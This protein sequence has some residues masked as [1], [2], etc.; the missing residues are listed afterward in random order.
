RIATLFRARRKLLYRIDCYRA[1]RS[2]WLSMDS[3]SPPDLIEVVHDDRHMIPGVSRLRRVGGHQHDES[4]AVGRQ[5]EVDA[6]AQACEM[7]GKPYPR[8]L[9]NKRISLDC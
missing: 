4:F 8:S 3:H 5:I 1:W 6:E 7:L 2:H 9:R